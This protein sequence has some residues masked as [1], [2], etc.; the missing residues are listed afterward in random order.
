MLNNRVS[1]SQK[2]DWEI[3]ICL[4]DKRLLKP[5]TSMAHSIQTGKEEVWICT[6]TKV[7]KPTILME[8]QRN[9]KEII[10][11]SVQSLN[12]AYREAENQ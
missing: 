9:Q 3:I 1:A 8:L 5:P 12:T 6:V 4:R 2:S 7:N 10:T 11:Y